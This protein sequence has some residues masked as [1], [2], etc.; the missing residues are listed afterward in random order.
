MHN[1]DFT[2]SFTGVFRYPPNVTVIDPDDTWCPAAAVA[3]LGALEAQS[4]LKP[5]RSRHGR[6]LGQNGVG[7]QPRPA[8]RRPAVTPTISIMQHQSGVTVGGIVLCGGHSRRMGSA[9]YAL[10]FGPQTMLQHMVNCLSDTLAPV[11]VVATAEQ[12]LPELPADIQ[13]ARD[14]HTDAGPLAGIHTGLVA[15]AP[16]TDAAYVTSCDAPFLRPALIVEMVNRL[17]SADLAIPRD[18]DYHHPLAAVYR[19]SLTGVIDRLLR[20]GARRPLSLFEQARVN[21][22]DVNTLRGVDPTLESFRN[23]NNPD[24]YRQAL[25][26]AG[27]PASP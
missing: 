12:Q 10:P 22:V 6:S 19:T 16:H 2:F 27:F 17:D 5:L 18:G 21:Q 14:I 4:V 15:L 3:A 8:M 11:V 24:D 25:I 1:T 9:K 13:I 20:S 7:T 26:D 23:L